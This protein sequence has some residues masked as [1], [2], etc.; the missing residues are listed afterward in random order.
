MA[1]I[2]TLKIFASAIKREE[3][4]QVVE[5]CNPPSSPSC[6]PSTPPLVIREEEH[7][8]QFITLGE[9]LE[10]TDRWVEKQYHSWFIQNK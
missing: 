2:P 8:V 5:L 7:D 1:N 9:Y 6:P 3:D 10:A 4:F